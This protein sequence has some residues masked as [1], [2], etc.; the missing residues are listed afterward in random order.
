M[1][2]DFHAH[3]DGEKFAADRAEVIARAKAA[4]V[5]HVVQVGQWRPRAAWA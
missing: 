4:G 5:G 1:L 3:L 2:V